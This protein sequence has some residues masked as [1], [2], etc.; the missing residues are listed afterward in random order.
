MFSAS[1]VT[2]DDDDDVEDDNNDADTD[3]R[4]RS[5][6]SPMSRQKIPPG[7]ASVTPQL[8]Q[9]TNYYVFSWIIGDCDTFYEQ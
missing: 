7:R 8:L 9:L 6:S 1:K 5:I 2:D 4:P 3:Q